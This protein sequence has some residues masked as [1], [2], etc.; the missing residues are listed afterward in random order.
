[1][2]PKTVRGKS[3]EAGFKRQKIAPAFPFEKW[4]SISASVPRATIYS[5][6]QCGAICGEE[7]VVFIPEIWGRELSVFFCSVINVVSSRYCIK[8]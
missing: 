5:S 6:I 7:V 8:Y 2:C 4:E 1:M 3:L